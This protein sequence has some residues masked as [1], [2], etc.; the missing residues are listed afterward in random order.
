VTHTDD[1]SNAPFAGPS[2]TGERIRTY[3]NTTLATNG[4]PREPRRFPPPGPQLAGSRTPAA[5]SG[6]SQ[7]PFS[8]PI[9]T[10]TKG[11]SL[12]FNSH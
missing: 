2:R 8:T 10:V 5:T 9:N 4:R 6:H 1:P 3:T 11:V 7:S 12:F